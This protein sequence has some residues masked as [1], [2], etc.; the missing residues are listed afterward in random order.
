MAVT[1]ETIVARSSACLA[2]EIGEEMVLMAVARGSYFGLDAIG[3][4]IW[5]RIG[6]PTRVGDLCA[7]LVA[8]YDAAPATI[9]ADLTDLLAHLAEL[10]LVETR[11]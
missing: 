6:N 8:E 3:A 2:A 4:D 7:A 5:R 11:E 1:S 9:L 10:G